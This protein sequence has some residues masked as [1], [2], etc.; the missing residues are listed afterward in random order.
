MYYSP[1]IVQLAGFASNQ[2]AL[3]LSLI[4][5]AMNAIGSILGIFL[6][7]RCGRKML[8]L[9]SLFG[10]FVSLGVLSGAFYLTSV[11]V[12]TVDVHQTLKAGYA[13]PTVIDFSQPLWNYN[14]CLKV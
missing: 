2:I 12:P 4:V 14:G 3:K 11:D 13:F 9:T 1:T 8:S 7:D 5:A 6:I 10:V